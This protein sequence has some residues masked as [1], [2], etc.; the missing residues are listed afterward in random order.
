VGCLL[1]WP[2]RDQ[3]G[4]LLKSTSGSSAGDAAARA[5]RSRRAARRMRRPYFT[6]NASSGCAPAIADHCTTNHAR[7]PAEHKPESRD[8]M[9]NAL[10]FLQH[11]MARSAPCG[12][13]QS[14]SDNS[15]RPAAML[16]TAALR[17]RG[18][19]LLRRCACVFGARTREVDLAGEGYPALLAVVCAVA[20]GITGAAFFLRPCA[21]M[22][23]ASCGLR[24][25]GLRLHVCVSSAIRRIHAP[26]GVAMVH[27]PRARH[28]ERP[29]APADGDREEEPP[30]GDF[31]LH[32]T[33]AAASIVSC[34][35]A[36]SAKE[37]LATRATA[38]RGASWRWPRDPV[39]NRTRSHS[40]G[41]ARDRAREHTRST[42]SGILAPRSRGR[43]G[44]EHDP[45]D[46]VGSESPPNSVRPA[47]TSHKTTPAEKTSARRSVRLWPNCR[48]PNR[49]IF[50]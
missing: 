38:S 44:H 2:L 17:L 39:R 48:A 14:V 42:A 10:V 4:A 1:Q 47:S 50:P 32:V 20:V 29:R 25:P 22:A 43:H 36:I 45:A 35:F 11:H 19:M 16:G 30:G 5:Q 3:R 31:A 9:E 37:L 21:S 46:D 7:R 15:C 6:D 12:A 28:P 49:P 23:C 26:R 24:C 27:Q 8:F 41:W 13:S 18:D 34:S 33:R 40:G